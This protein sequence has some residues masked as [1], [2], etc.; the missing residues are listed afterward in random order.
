MTST[1]IMDQCSRIEPPHAAGERELACSFLDWQRATLLCKLEGLPDAE[2]RRRHQPSGLSLLWLV[3]HLAL[4]E[5]SWFQVTFASEI[6][7]TPDRQAY[8]AQEAIGPDDSAAT[9]IAFYQAEVERSRAIVA[10]APSFDDPAQQPSHGRDVTLR[11]IILHMIE[12]TARHNGHA[13]LLR[14]AIDGQVGE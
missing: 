11:W 6:A 10:A 2:L 14:E 8:W 4:V 7:Y 12:E 3:K 1:T 5:R 9:V 13:D